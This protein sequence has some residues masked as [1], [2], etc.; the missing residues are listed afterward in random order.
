MEFV[1][2]SKE[3]PEATLAGWCGFKLLHSFMPKVFYHRVISNATKNVK[4]FVSVS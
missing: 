4:P 1:Q 3:R 2:A